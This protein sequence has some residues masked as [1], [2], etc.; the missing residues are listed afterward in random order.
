M[1]NHV[2][3]NPNLLCLL[4]NSKHC[5]RVRLRLP[6]PE[7]CSEGGDGVSDGQ[8]HGGR[9]RRAHRDLPEA[10]KH[11]GSAER[12]A[13]SRSASLRLNI[14]NSYPSANPHEC[15]TSLFSLQYS[16]VHASWK[17]KHPL[18]FTREI[19]TFWFFL[20]CSP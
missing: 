10:A 14:S 13:R 8:Q 6:R 12:R 20:S 17:H 11:L 9:H 19:L 1:Q 4:A 15:S 5:H 7:Y 3:R 16:L 2:P 18:Q